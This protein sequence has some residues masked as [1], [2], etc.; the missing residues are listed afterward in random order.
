MYYI[1]GVF[2]A[3][4]F[5]KSRKKTKMA[6]KKAWKSFANIFP[7]FLGVIIFVGIMLAI[8][9]EETVS[10]VIGAE[11][12]ALGVAIASIVGSI[13]LIPG[14]IAFPMAKVLL[15]NGAGI[16]QIGVFISTLMMV[17][18]ATFP[19]EVEYFGKKVAIMRNVMSYFLS[20]IVAYIIGKVVG[21][22]WF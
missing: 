22:V 14:F 19:V 2:L 16:M 18:I 11:S 10:R 1:A 8:F 4:S 15:D 6:L 9:D 13:T 12:G 5:F 17:G 7:K 3:L 21:G 20:F